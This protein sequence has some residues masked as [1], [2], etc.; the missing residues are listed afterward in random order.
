MPAECS[1]CPARHS[2][3]VRLLFSRIRGQTLSHAELRTLSRR[4]TRLTLV[5]SPSTSISLILLSLLLLWMQIARP[6]SALRLSVRMF[7]ADGAKPFCGSC[8]GERLMVSFYT[9][10]RY[11]EARFDRHWRRSRWLRGCHQGWS[12]G[13]EGYLRREAWHPGW[14]VASSSFFV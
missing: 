13:H 4:R 6:Q 3:F 5:S 8:C 7:S 12:V 14:Y 9:M 10:F 1:R 11:R 2:H